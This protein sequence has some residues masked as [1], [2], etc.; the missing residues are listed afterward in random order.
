MPKRKVTGADVHLGTLRAAWDLD[1]SPHALVKAA[2]ERAEGR[3]R[4]PA[5][6]K[7]ITLDSEVADSVAQHVER[8][9]AAT[10]SAAINQAAARWAANQDLGLALDELYAEDPDAKPS[11]E[12]VAKAAA[13]FGL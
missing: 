9:A 7:S 10:F 11:E 12:D 13:K 2:T 4:K 3:P 8:G 5:Q 6:K 1:E